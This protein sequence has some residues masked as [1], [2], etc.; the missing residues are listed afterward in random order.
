MRAA[1]D[2]QKMP[3][4]TATTGSG[5]KQPDKRRV[6]KFSPH[7]PRRRSVASGTVISG[8]ARSEAAQSDLDSECLEN[9]N[10]PS[11]AP[12]ASDESTYELL[13]CGEFSL[14]PGKRLGT[15]LFPS[16]QATSL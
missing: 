11:R 14:A 1:R 15:Y 9:I 3:A 2:V 4:A 10:F 13:S 8:Q 6:T 16:L 5:L 12:F 7:L